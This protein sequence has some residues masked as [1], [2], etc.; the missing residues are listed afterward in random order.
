MGKVAFEG[1]SAEA[2]PFFLNSMPEKT[3]GSRSHVIDL[4]SHAGRASRYRP[5]L[6][7]LELYGESNRPLLNGALKLGAPLKVCV[8]FHL[9][10][11]APNLDVTLAFETNLGQCILL[12]SSTFQSD[13][14]T[15]DRTGDRTF[16]CDIPSLPLL[17]AE[18]KIAALLDINGSN[19]DRVVD[20]ARITVVASDY[21]GGGRLPHHGFLAV[22]HQWR[23]AQS[24]SRA[25]PLASAGG[26]HS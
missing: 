22:E 24:D 26:K 17:P 2:I 7:S 5:L 4:R 13:P 23:D 21:Y 11:P 20:A 14:P 9:E 1:P 6:T 12:I 19:I 16:V 10:E 8:S 3:S 18:Y 25:K 15:G